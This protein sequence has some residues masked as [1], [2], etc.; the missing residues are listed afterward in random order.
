MAA[1]MLVKVLGDND[2]DLGYAFEDLGPEDEARLRKPDHPLLPVYCG[3][4]LCG[5]VDKETGKYIP[6]R[7]WIDRVE[8]RHGD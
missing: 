6:N 8:A 3:D 1:L 5:R 2:E 7:D 4:E